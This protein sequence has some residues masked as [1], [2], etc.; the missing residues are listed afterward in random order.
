MRAVWLGLLVWAASGGVASAQ[1]V[2]DINVTVR[3][4]PGRSAGSFD[5]MDLATVAANPISASECNTM[6]SFRFSTPLDA[7]RSQLQFYVGAMCDVV[8][9]RTDTTST[10]CVA[11]DM[12]E[13]VA[14]D[15]RQQVDY[16]IRAGDL[17]PC[18]SGTGSGVQNIWVLAVDNNSSEVTGTGQK[19]QFNIAYDLTPPG[20]PTSLV[21][22]GGEN[23]VELTWDAP[24]EA[25]QTYEVYFD[26]SGCADGTPTGSLS[27][28][29]ASS[30]LY[31]EFSGPADSYQLIWPE[32]VPIGG[33]AAIAVRGVDSSNN[34]GPLSDVICVERIDVVSWRD[35][36]CME[37]PDACDDTGGCSAS[38]GARGS[39]G[40]LALMS[41]LGLVLVWRRRR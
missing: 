6:I 2:S 32:S 1:T 36:Y 22:D 18:D 35:V 21:A 30:L 9:I 24:S 33:E 12:I 26:P 37:N 19:A 40:A 8:S 34:A 11:L 29:P 38:P 15:G 4:F 5:L 25:V 23:S 3:S 27:D 41:L 17:V 13:P 7:T 28:P 16:D 10:M 20:G 31:A 14:I 39:L